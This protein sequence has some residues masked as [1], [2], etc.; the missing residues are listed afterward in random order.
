MTLDK[1]FAMNRKPPQQTRRL[2]QYLVTSIALLSL[3]VQGVLVIMATTDDRAHWN[4]AE[5]EALLQ[6]L[7]KNKSEMGESGSFP[8]STFSKAAEAIKPLLSAGPVKTGKM[9]KGKWTSVR[10]I[11][12]L[13]SVPLIYG[14]LAKRNIP[15]YSDLSRAI[16]V[17][18]G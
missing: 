9:C 3:C 16:W 2:N 10:T 14:S 15:C 17:S 12:P 6:F 4:D 11:T 5:T 1:A 8:S 13:S 18:L 7:L